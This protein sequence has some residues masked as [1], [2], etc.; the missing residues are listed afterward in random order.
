VGCALV[1]AAFR[2]G[3]DGAPDDVHAAGHH[4]H[5]EPAYA[6]QVQGLGLVDPPLRHDCVLL[7]SRCIV[8]EEDDISR[9]QKVKIY[10]V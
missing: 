3:R 10:L 5:V 7:K 9:L 6:G 8:S 4:P 1:G 2:G